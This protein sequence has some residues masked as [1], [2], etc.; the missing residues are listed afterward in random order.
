MRTQAK[1]QIRPP[2]I[3]KK[4][5]LPIVVATLLWPVVSNAAIYSFD[6]GLTPATPSGGTGAWD[7]GSAIWSLAGADTVW[8]NDGTHTATFGGTAGTVTIGGTTIAANALNF[9][10][11]GYIVTGGT[12]NLSGA[13]PTLTNAASVSTTITS[14]LTGTNGL[15]LAGGNGS[16]SFTINNAANTFSGGISINSGILTTNTAGSL[17]TNVINLN[18]GTFT[19]R[20]NLTNNL[21]VTANSTIDMASTGPTFTVGALSIGAQTL[22]IGTGSN[23][24]NGTVSFGATTL[25]GNAIISNSKGGGTRTDGSATFSTV[26]V[27][28]SVAT[29]TTTTFTLTSANTGLTRTRSMS[30]TGALSDNA[31]DST[32]KL[33]FTINSNVGAPLT[34]TLSGINTYTGATTVNSNASLIVNGSLA[35][36]SLV[37]VNSGALLGGSGTI[38]GATTFAAGSKLS[39]GSNSTATLTFSG[40]LD[41]SAAANNTAAFVFTLG[42]AFDKI[43]AS[44]LTLGTNVLDAA[45]FSL[46]TGTGFASGQSY[47]LFEN[48]SVTGTFTSFAVSN[49]GGSG[50]DGTVSLNGNNIVLTTSAIPEPSTY[51]LLLGAGTALLAGFRR[52][53]S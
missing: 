37:T 40:G 33:A 22:S 26:S 12:L 52:R 50:I 13:T 20:A 9:N 6:P 5:L 17:G 16:S 24:S 30:V 11:T 43:V 31:S 28:D 2:M 23:V 18:G 53:R 32:K 8:G 48:T 35:S 27:G 39:A 45:D 49:I 15:V 38:G 19:P 46:T 42:T 21:L 7:T 34:V 14:L 51:A 29:G 1:A 10:T 47:T 44:S 3:T 36:G 41:I 25:T 4:K